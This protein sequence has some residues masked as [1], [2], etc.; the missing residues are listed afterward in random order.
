MK[1]L[2]NCALGDVT[3]HVLSTTDATSHVT[4]A[5]HA[6][7]HKEIA[8]DSG[9]AHCTMTSAKWRSRDGHCHITQTIR[10]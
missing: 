3:W 6:T 8:V 1:E 4:V 2:F 9:A 5:C 7:L 10:N